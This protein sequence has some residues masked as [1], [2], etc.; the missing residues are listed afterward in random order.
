M[1]FEGVCGCKRMELVSGCVIKNI[2]IRGC[3]CVL[4][5]EENE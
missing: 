2:E 4:F 5:E 1:Y 3:I